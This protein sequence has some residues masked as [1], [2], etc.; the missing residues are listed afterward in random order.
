MA[1]GS[2][3]GAASR[4]ASRRAPAPVTVRSMVDSSEPWRLPESV[5]VSSR[6]PRVAGSISMIVPAETCTGRS[7]IGL[8]ASWVLPR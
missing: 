7:S 2:V 5:R 8:A 4:E 3:S 6:D 1:A